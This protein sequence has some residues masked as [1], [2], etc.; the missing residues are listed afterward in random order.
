MWILSYCLTSI[1]GAS[2][3]AKILC[4]DWGR[5]QFSKTLG[6]FEGRSPSLAS[7]VQTD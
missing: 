1:R 4:Y 3:M 7:D 5:S 6:V 2:L